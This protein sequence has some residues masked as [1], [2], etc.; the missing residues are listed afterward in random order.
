MSNKILI[1]KL[2]AKIKVKIGES[3][4]EF[5]EPNGILKKFESG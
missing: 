2:D 4:A 5:S 3:E 1:E